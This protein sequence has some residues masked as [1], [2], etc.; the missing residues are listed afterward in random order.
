MQVQHP[1]SELVIDKR[2]LTAN[3]ALIFFSSQ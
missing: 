2:S 1:G 3:Q